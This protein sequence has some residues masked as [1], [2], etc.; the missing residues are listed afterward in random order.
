MLWE[1]GSLQEALPTTDPLF[2]GCCFTRLRKIAGNPVS[3]GLVWRQPGAPWKGQHSP[4]EIEI[5]DSG[6]QGITLHQRALLVKLT[7]QQNMFFLL[8]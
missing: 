7:I 1:E 6:T 5:V 3:P 2:R 8:Q 4:A